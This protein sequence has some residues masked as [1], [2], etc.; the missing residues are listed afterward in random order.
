MNSFIAQFYIVPLLFLS[1]SSHNSSYSP[2]F[3]STTSSTSHKSTLSPLTSL[4]YFLPLIYSPRNSVLTSSS[5]THTSSLSHLTFF[6]FTLLST[7]S[8]L[9]LFLPQIHWSSSFHN[10]LLPIFH[11]FLFPSLPFFLL[12]P[13]HSTSSYKFFLFLIPPSQ[14]LSSP[15][16]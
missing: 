12:Q 16:P 2:S 11:L 13:A 6:F 3:Y 14:F 8:Y 9:V 7:S 5:I 15:S 10:S 4:L 1:F